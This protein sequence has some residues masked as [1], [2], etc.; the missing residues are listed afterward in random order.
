MPIVPR[1][2]TQQ[3]KLVAEALSELGIGYTQQ[4]EF[5][6]YT[7]D[8][9]LP[10]NNIVIEA[11]GVWGHLRKADRKRNSELLEA[12][13]EIKDILHV[14]STTKSEILKEIKEYFGWDRTD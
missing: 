13:T 8:F 12:N 1:D 6:T 11:D 3:E 4:L 5:G 9:F 10:D 14:K 2:F 7:V